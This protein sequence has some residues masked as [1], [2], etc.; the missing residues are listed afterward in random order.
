MPFKPQVYADLLAQK[1]EEY[2][3]QGLSLTKIKDVIEF[4]FEDQNVLQD[5]ALFVN[6]MK[7]TDR[8]KDILL[9][10]VEKKRSG[11]L[12]IQDLE[13]GQV[14][15]LKIDEKTTEYPKDFWALAM[16]NTLKDYLSRPISVTFES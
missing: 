14:S 12:K 4:G 3:K 1:I 9:S 13:N 10:I 2:T 6:E 15:V 8:E 7:I 16:M 5:Y 11:E